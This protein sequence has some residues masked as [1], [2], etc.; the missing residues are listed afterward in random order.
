M[1]AVGPFG[2]A[3]LA[4]RSLALREV[5]RRHPLDWLPAQ[6]LVV[7]LE[8]AHSKRSHFLEQTH[9][10]T[11][12]HLRCIVSSHQSSFKLT[13]IE[14]KK[15]KKVQLNF[16]HSLLAAELANRDRV[17]GGNWNKIE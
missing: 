3:S 12:T 1:G 15:K 2:E 6:G 4:Y 11:N 8:L 10:H 5:E 9:T 14:N 7:E 17:L 16:P 13:R